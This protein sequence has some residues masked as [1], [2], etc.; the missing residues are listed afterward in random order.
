MSKTEIKRRRCYVLS[1]DLDLNLFRVE[2]QK[3]VVYTTPGIG[4]RSLIECRSSGGLAQLGEHY[5][6]NVGVGG[7]IPLPSTSLR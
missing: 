6:R 1:L 3:T 4:L 5:V 2:T 7:S